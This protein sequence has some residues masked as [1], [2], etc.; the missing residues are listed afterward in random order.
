MKT[1]YIF[2]LAIIALFALGACESGAGE[3][4]TSTIRGKVIIREWDGDFQQLR[5]TYP[6]AKED[7]YIIYGDEYVYGD[8]FEASMDGTYEFKYLKKGSYTIFAYSKDSIPP[9]TAEKVPVSQVVEI[10]GD[11]QVVEVP[12][13]IILK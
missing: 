9:F 4:G 5:G 8:R 2:T 12:D 1:R 7:V 10:T 3:G 11:N 13:I 6:A